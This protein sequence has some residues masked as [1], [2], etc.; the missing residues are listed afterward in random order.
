MEVLTFTKELIITSFVGHLG[1]LEL[2]ALVLAQTLYN[3]TGQAPMMGVVSAMETFCGQ[4]YGARKY[5]LVGVI[6]QRAM[7]I[8]LLMCL[9][10]V[11][12][13]AHAQELL[14]WMGQDPDIA[15]AAGG[16]AEDA[17]HEGAV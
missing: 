9:G 11:G 14:L 10:A 13:W 12:I 17:A 3:V 15:R 8:V 16:P 5:A 7:I 6:L 4:A 1:P 2:S